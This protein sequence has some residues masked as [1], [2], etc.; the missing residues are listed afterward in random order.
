L[1]LN[2][3]YSLTILKARQRKSNSVILPRCSQRHKVAERSGVERIWVRSW[4]TCRK[5]QTPCQ[6][7]SSWA[8]RR[9]SNVPT[10]NYEVLAV[11]HTARAGRCHPDRSGGISGYVISNYKP[12]TIKHTL[13][14]TTYSPTVRLCLD[15]SARSKWQCERFYYAWL[16]DELGHT[17]SSTS[18]FVPRK[19]GAGWPIC[20]VLVVLLLRLRLFWNITP[21]Q[22]L[23]FVQE[24]QAGAKTTRFVY[25]AA[26]TIVKYTNPHIVTINHFRCL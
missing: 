15:F 8:C 2:T 23:H 5:A 22:I 17:D 21:A 9:I 10:S 3:K 7:L 26:P 1:I 25:T 14:S 4:S 13:P 11:R 12:I 16:V 20:L 24:W 18:Y 19:R 6:R